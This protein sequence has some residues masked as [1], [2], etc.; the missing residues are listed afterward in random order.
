MAFFGGKLPQEVHQSQK[1]RFVNMIFDVLDYGRAG[2]CGDCGECVVTVTRCATD[3][4]YLCAAARG[5]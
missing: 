5:N 4:P 3:T 1:P 2:G